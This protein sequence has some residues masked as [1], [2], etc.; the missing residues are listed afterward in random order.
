MTQG[1]LLDTNT[2]IDMLK[3]RRGVQKQVVEH[4]PQNCFISDITVSELMTGYYLSGNPIEKRDIDFVK[5]NFTI[6][7]VTPSV[8]DKF[9]E[10]RA[11][12]HKK[13]CP[14]PSL[15]LII[16]ATASVNNLVPVSHDSHFS[17]F[18]ELKSE[19]WTS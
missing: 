4:G 2:V 15:D 11:A 8:L 1:Y 5:E 19:D 17:I 9:A 7:R 14:I 16:L 3:A 12:L 13:G 6:L 10:Y 18:P